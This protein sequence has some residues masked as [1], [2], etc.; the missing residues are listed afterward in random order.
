MKSSIFLLIVAIIL[1]SGNSVATT[2]K[3]TD[4]DE[5]ITC[6]KKNGE[7]NA[8]CFGQ[9]DEKSEGDL[10]KSYEKKLKQLSDY[11]YENW[12]MGSKDQKDAMLSAFKENQTEWKR[13]RNN[14]CQVASTG[15][16]NTHSY[17][18]TLLSCIINMNLQRIGDINKINPDLVE[19]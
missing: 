15:A 7:E 1:L 18:G 8:E 6:I 13:Y 5:V 9:L 19:E 11:N 4:N 14:Y 10:N 2:S 16:E 12:W 3:I 17:A